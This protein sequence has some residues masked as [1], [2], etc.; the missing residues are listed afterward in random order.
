[1][2]KALTCCAGRA[3]RIPWKPLA[4]GCEI[5]PRARWQLFDDYNA[6]N[7]TV[8]FSRWNGSAGALHLLPRCLTHLFG[9]RLQF[10]MATVRMPG[11]WPSDR[12]IA[13]A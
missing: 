1:M 10:V 5:G 7:A 9:N 12:L 3:A 13:R 8:A 4:R 6:R 2:T 11:Q